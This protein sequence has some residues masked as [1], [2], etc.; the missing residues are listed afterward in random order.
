MPKS[1]SAQT[2][3]VWANGDELQHHEILQYFSVHFASGLAV[4]VNLKVCRD[5]PAQA[6]LGLAELRRHC[7]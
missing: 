5:S 3:C 7:D 6:S 1:L 2:M 4:P